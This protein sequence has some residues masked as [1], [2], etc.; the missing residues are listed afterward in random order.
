MTVDFMLMDENIGYQEENWKRRMSAAV[1]SGNDMA[2][3][4]KRM[5]VTGP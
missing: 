2:V 4:M 1:N 5:E 3:G